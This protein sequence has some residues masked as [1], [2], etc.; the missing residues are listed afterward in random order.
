MAWNGKCPNGGPANFT[1]ND[2]N[3]LAANADYTNTVSVITSATTGGDTKKASVWVYFVDA[4]GRNWRLLMTADVHPNAT[5]PAGQ[6]GH[7]YISGW[8]GWTP[9]TL[10]TSTAVILPLPA[11]SG[12]FPPGNTRYPT[13]VPAPAPVPGAAVPATT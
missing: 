3:N 11:N 13:V 9:R 5:N 7:T 4:A 10:A 2:A 8:D 6:S 12:T 1:N